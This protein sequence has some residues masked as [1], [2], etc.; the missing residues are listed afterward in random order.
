MA[1]DE[2]R[3]RTS[4]TGLSQQL[5]LPVSTIHTALVR[6]REIG[7]V[8]G[9]TQGLRVLDPKRL[10]LLWAARRSL[11]KDLNYQTHVERPIREIEG[12]LPET[13]IPTA[14]TA[15]VHHQGHNTV[16]DYDQVV[17]YG[18][19][20]EV[21]RAFPARRGYPN[22]IV[23]DPDPL[24]TNYGRYAP[25]PQVYAD[26]F[27]LPTWQAQRFL[28]ALN[29]Q[30]LFTDR[31][32]RWE[33]R[34]LAA[35]E[36]H[37]LRRAVS[38]DGRTDVPSMHHQLDATS[39]AWHLGAV[40]AKGHIVATSSF[41]VVAC[42]LRPDARPAVQLQFMAVDPAV[43][44]M[45]AGTAIMTDA[46][47]RLKATGAVLLW[48]SARDSAVPFYERFGFVTIDGSGFTPPETGRPHQTIV[49]DLRGSDRR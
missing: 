42:P 35:E 47:R 30:V 25:M 14:Y 36:T 32:V 39:G 46:L 29:R 31:G 41:Y 3:R 2:D 17:I 28:E 34:E 9:S 44:G 43:Q 18:D 49:L 4:I 27:N 13:A 22:L 26:L 24:L 38:A 45:G 37:A 48:A 8:R 10:L 5:A 7:A 15:L 33:V 6:P 19:R 11:S 12:R 40:D 23:L 16:A 21:Q 1:F 20:A